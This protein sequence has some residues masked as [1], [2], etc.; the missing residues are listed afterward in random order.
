MSAH[1][2][3]YLVVLRSKTLLNASVFCLLNVLFAKV[4]F[5]QLPDVDGLSVIEY[6]VKKKPDI[7]YYSQVTQFYNSR[8]ISSGFKKHKI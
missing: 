4:A 5:K 2:V 3:F 1:Q 7:P 6:C 8:Y